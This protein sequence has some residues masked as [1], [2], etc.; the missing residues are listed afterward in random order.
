MLKLAF[1]KCILRVLIH[2]QN[3]T[4]LKLWFFFLFLLMFQVKMYSE[5]LWELRTIV[6]YIFGIILNY[7]YHQ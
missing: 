7:H 4:V 2:L 1:K 5:A 6:A 3:V